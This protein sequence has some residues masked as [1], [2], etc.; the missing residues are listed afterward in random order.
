MRLIKIT[1]AFQFYVISDNVKATPVVYDL[2]LGFEVKKGCQFFKNSKSIVIYISTEEVGILLD[3]LNF[4][5]KQPRTIL[6]YL[7]GI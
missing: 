1:K 3:V 4:V 7:Q 6:N 2:T 5:E